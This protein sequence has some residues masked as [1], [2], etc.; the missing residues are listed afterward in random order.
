MD[1]GREYY[2]EEKNDKHFINFIQSFMCSITLQLGWRAQFRAHFNWES[3]DRYGTT[4][5]SVIRLCFRSFSTLSRIYEIEYRNIPTCMESWT[6][7]CPRRLKYK[8][9]IE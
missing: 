2:G 3:F 7:V 1:E 9:S 5:L 4:V 8:S 6:I